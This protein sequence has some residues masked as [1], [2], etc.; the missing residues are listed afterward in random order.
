MSTWRYALLGGVPFALAGCY[1]TPAYV[2]TSPPAV[3]TQTAPPAEAPEP[4]PVAS[5]AV[6]AAAPVPAVVV[7]GALAAC[8]PVPLT[9]PETAPLPPVSEQQ[10]TWQPGHWD[11]NG[12][13]YVWSPGR[14]VPLGGHGTRWQP[15]FWSFTGACVWVPAH[16]L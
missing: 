5:P 9:Q 14:W 12:S 8:P 10:L 1:V 11:W 4:A 7:P 2:T 6:V 3:V 13:S 15:G 16:W